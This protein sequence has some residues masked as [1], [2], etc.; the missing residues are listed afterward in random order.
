MRPFEVP[1]ES[2][3]AYHAAAV[4]RLQLP[5]RARG[6]GGRA[7]R[8]GRRRGRA[9]AARA[10]SSCAPPRTGPSAAPTALTGPIARGDEATVERHRDGA[11]ARRRP[12]SSP[13]YEAL[14]ER[15]RAIAQ[16]RR[17]RMKV[18]RTKAELREALAAPRRDGRAD[19]PRADDGLPARGPPLAAARRRASD[20][21]V[22]VMSLFVNPTQFGPGEDL[23]AYPRDE[24][25]RRRARRA[26]RASTCVYAPAPRRS[27]REGFATAVEVGGG[28][29][30]RARRRP[31][32]ARP[33]A[34][35]RRHHRRREAVQPVAARRRLLRPEGR[36]AG[37]RDPADG[38]ATS[39][40]RS[41]SWSCRRSARPTASR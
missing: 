3:A 1:E 25:A 22:V 2:R 28:L 27:T 24:D 41:R 19:R 38:R 29:T 7:A 39:T 34:L 35:P 31:G 5:R 18:V 26:R 32:A 33:G 11:R 30:E 9:R 13:L 23:D 21:D 16:D 8:A 40:S 37:G 4:D 10:R 12:S 36:P 20:C 17:R 15:A 6:V 14:A